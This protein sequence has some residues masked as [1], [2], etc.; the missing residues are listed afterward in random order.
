M[1]SYAEFI[2]EKKDNPCWKG[3]SMVGTKLKDGK[4]VP[5]CVKDENLEEMSTSQLVG[6]LLSLMADDKTFPEVKDSMRKAIVGSPFYQ[7]KNSLAKRTIM[8]DI[9]KAKNVKD[10]EKVAKKYNLESLLVT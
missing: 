7:V 6:N 5:N 3:Y 10:F 8:A 1:K 4:K 9:D 2:A